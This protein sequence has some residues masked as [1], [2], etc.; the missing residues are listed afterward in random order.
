MAAHTLKSG[1][2]DMGA[3]ALAALFARLEALGNQG[4]LDGVAALVAEAETLFSQVAAELSSIRN[5][6]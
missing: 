4:E 6:R 3:A 1:S 2:T 5:A